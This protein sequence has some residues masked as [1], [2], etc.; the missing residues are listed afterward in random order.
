MQGLQNTI[1][2]FKNSLGGIHGNVTRL[3][4]KLDSHL[5]LCV[6][7]MASSSIVQIGVPKLI[8]LIINLKNSSFGKSNRTHVP[9]RMEL[10]DIGHIPN[11]C[12][13]DEYCHDD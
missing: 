10:E 11:G 7:N 8:D 4:Q 5:S 2:G 3:E 9:R 12:R 6:H 13:D 1:T